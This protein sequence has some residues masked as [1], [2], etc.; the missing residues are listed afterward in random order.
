MLG[1]SY[2]A[3]ALFTGTAKGYCGKKIS[4]F[5][6]KISDAIHNTVRQAWSIYIARIENS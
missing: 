1:Y 6:S 2:S 4:E 3:I 5:T